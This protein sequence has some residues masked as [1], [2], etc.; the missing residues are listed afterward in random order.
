M[1]AIFVILVQGGF[2]GR[3]VA[4]GNNVGIWIAM[5]WSIHGGW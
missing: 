1:K 2:K 4:W 5:E 3:C